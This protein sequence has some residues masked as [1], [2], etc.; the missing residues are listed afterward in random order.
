MTRSPDVPCTRCGKLLWRSRKAPSER[1]CRQC[2]RGVSPPYISAAEQ[3]CGR[4]RIV[5]PLEDF[6]PSNRGHAGTYCRACNTEY[7]RERHKAR[8]LLLGR[9]PVCDDCGTETDRHRTSQGLYCTACSAARR[10]A[11]YSRKNYTRRTALRH[12]DITAP[13]IGQLRREARRCPMCSVKL[14]DEPNQPNSKH[15]DHIVPVVIG[16]THT[17]GNVRIICRTCNLRRPKD[18]SD[19]GGH[20]PTLW[21][22]DAALAAVAARTRR[23][24]CDR[25]GARKR[26]GRCWSCN[27]RQEA[28]SLRPL[29]PIAA[30]MRNDGMKWDEIS[31]ALGLKGAG[32]A[33][34]VAHEYGHVGDLVESDRE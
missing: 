5:R 3:P 1:V 13:Y 24:Q 11:W 26:R 28:A 17:V 2:Q 7:S 33:Y 15:L 21:A 12:T 6:A 9:R 18:G 25:C 29:G 20:Q 16:G 4:C 31:D 34:R 30:Q 8:A 14:T 23:G 27:P 10:H 22:Q 32:N 19:L